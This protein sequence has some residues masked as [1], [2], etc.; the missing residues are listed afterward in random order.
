MHCNPIPPVSAASDFMLPTNSIHAIPTKEFQQTIQIKYFSPDWFAGRQC[1]VQ[2]LI[3]TDP[4]ILTKQEEQAVKLLV[5]FN[6]QAHYQGIKDLEWNNDA[7]TLAS[8]YFQFKQ[9]LY[10]LFMIDTNTQLL[11]TTRLRR[12]CEVQLY[13]CLVY[14]EIRFEFYFVLDD[15]Q[16][17][18]KY[19]SGH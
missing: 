18:N 12:N 4:D 8:D 2:S 15:R 5:N 16:S 14:A 7:F 13:R 17:Q 10:I 1:L 11:I 3:P 19:P 9:K 6:T